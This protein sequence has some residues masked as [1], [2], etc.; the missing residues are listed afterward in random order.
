MQIDNLI[1]SL[2]RICG[3]GPK[4]MR[5]IAQYLLF[6]PHMR[7]WTCVRKAN[8]TKWAVYPAYAGMN[9]LKLSD[10]KIDVSLPRIRGDG[11]YEYASALHSWWFPMQAHGANPLSFMV[12]DLALLEQGISFILIFKNTLQ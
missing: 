5:G 3:D 4:A 1:K 10:L 6:T 12:K 2:P 11:P 7:G 8:P 9:L